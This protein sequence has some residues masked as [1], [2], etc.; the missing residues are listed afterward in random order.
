MGG[1][2]HQDMG[3]ELRITRAALAMLERHRQHPG[4][5][6]VAVGAVVVAP[7]PDPVPLQVADAHVEGLGP[8]LGACRRVWSLPPAASSDTLSGELKQWSNDC[9]RSLTRLPRCCQARSNPSPYSARGSV[10]R[11]LRHSRSTV[12]TLTRLPPPAR[13]AAWT[14]RTSP[15]SA[16]D[17]P[18][19]CSSSAPCSGHAA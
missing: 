1:V 9:T 13:Q 2:L 7:H 17:L 5:D 11:T 6:V 4:V 8:S 12:S 15:L 18:K 10:P 19:S 14:E 16:F 3:V